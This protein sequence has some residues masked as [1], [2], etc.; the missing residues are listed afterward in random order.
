MVLPCGMGMWWRGGVKDG[1]VLVE[2]GVQGYLRWIDKRGLSVPGGVQ[3]Y[4][5]S[6]C[7]FAD[8]GSQQLESKGKCAH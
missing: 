5:Q 8:L 6:A 7:C 3:L 2:V 1:A 4:Q